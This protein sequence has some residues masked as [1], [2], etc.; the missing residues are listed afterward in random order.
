LAHRSV[1]H[2][3]TA[4]EDD[5]ILRDSPGKLQLLL[6]QQDSH[7]F[8]FEREKNVAD[9]VHHVWLNA[10]G[11]FVENQQVWRECQSSSDRELLLLPTREISAPPMKHL[12]EYWK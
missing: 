4:V 7:A 1:G 9:L 11:W 8:V 2:G 5:E 3:A 6:H 12:F 10:L